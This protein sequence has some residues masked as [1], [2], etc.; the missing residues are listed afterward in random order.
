MTRGAI[1]RLRPWTFHVALGCASVVCAA[2]TLAAQT[3]ARP[4]TPTSPKP[5]KFVAIG[6]VSRQ[7]T[8]N[9]GAAAKGGA[10]ILTD[11]RGE[12][13]TV[14]RLDGDESTLAFH[15]GHMVEVAGPVTAAPAGRGA[16]RPGPT[17]KVGSLT[18]ISRSCSTTPATD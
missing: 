5:T 14:Y 7:P 11:T 10:F 13:P 6:C 3:P 4:S 17:L 16:N 2:S 18:Y 12:Q 8:G 15:V 1:G 9:A